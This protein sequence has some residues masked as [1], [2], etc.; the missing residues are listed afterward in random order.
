MNLKKRLFALWHGDIPLVKTYWLYGLFTSV[1]VTVL[2]VLIIEPAR[3]SMDTNVA[4]GT[5]IVLFLALICYSV[6]IYVGIWRAAGKYEGRRLWGFLAKASVVWWVIVSIAASVSTF[7]SVKQI[8][9]LQRLADSKEIEI[10]HERYEGWQ[11]VDIPGR[12]SFQIPPTME[13]QSELN[14]EF[15]DSLI[16]PLLSD[17]IMVQQKGLNE[18]ESKAFDTFARIIIYPDAQSEVPGLKLGSNLRTF[19]TQK[20]LD[21]LSN[22]LRKEFEISAPQNPLGDVIKIVSWGGTNIA[23]VNNYTCL[24][25]TFMRTVND[26]PPAKVYAYTI[27]N[28]EKIHTITVSY[29]ITDSD[30]WEGDLEKVINTFNFYTN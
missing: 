13:L 20:D 9:A 28:S 10:Q 23:D 3:S 18:R 16:G 6:V 27:Y 21:A 30:K 22:I 19:F 1:V 11:D 24:L 14:K 26:N 4:L 17:A 15:Q 12:F 8:V 5:F 29:R 25:T 2:N 7:G